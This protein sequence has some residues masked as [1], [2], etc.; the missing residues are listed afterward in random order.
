MKWAAPTGPAREAALF[1]ISPD[2]HTDDGRLQSA[3][4]LLRAEAPV[5]WVEPPGMRP[6]WLVSRYADV[7]AVERRGA[8]FIAGPRSVLSSE[9]GEASMRQ[10]SGKPDV[11]RSLFQMDDPEHRAYRDIATPWFAQGGVSQLDAKIV[12]CAKQAVAHIH[13][14]SGTFDLMAEVAVPFPMRIMMHIL[15]LPAADDAMV[16][17]FVR[18]LTGAEDP[19]RRLADRP[20]ESMRLAGVQ[21]RDYFNRITTE[22][23]MCPATDLS[24]AIAN[25]QVKAQ[26][27]PDYERISYFIQLAI[28]G[29]ENTSY[30]I[31]GGMHALI[32]H[33]AQFAKLQ[34]NPAL[35]DL[36]V[37]EMLRW[38]SPGRHLV[39]TATA[40][41]A[42]GGQLIREGE[43]VA[44]FFNSAN[45]DEAVFDRPNEFHIDRE[46]NPHLTFGLGPHFCLGVH[47]ARIELRALFRSLLPRLISAEITGTPRRARSAVISGISFLPLRC[48]WK[49]LPS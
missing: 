27:I 39:R 8:P 48:V 1:V 22:R 37:E 43:A 25:A 45:R 10:I 12:A 3:F 35:I 32:T 2:G 15:G 14:R 31:G 20:A 46:P 5:C 33:P 24:S 13:G 19:D 7:M 21:L 9:A 34:A 23:R 49:G 47:L 29:Q 41:V 28:A 44:L 18:G 16:L 4:A 26:P 11:L 30:C 42:I 40:D 6:F 38:T 17:K 36:A